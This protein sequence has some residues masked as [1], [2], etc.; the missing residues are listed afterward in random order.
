MAKFRQFFLKL[1][2]RH[3]SVI[4]FPDNNFSTR[5]SIFFKLGICI[6]IV[7]IWFGFSNGQ[8]SSFFYSYPPFTRYG[9]GVI[10]FHVFILF[11]LLCII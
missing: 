3:T 4:S 2:V 10:S 11:F 5:Q 9:G 8:I 6:D 1:S 7:D